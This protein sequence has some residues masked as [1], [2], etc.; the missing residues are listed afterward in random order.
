MGQKMAFWQSC[1]FAKT[2]PLFEM[3][4]KYNIG[5]NYT[6]ADIQALQLKIEL[7]E[8][9]KKKLKKKV[10]EY[11]KFEKF[12]ASDSNEREFKKFKQTR[13]QIQRVRAVNDE[14]RQMSD[15]NAI[16]QDFPLLYRITYI[17]YLNRYTNRPNPPAPKWEYPK[18][19]YIG[20]NVG[21]TIAQIKARAILLIERHWELQNQNGVEVEIPFN[22]IQNTIPGFVFAN[23]H[24]QPHLAQ[25]LRIDDQYIRDITNAP[26]FNQLIAL[27]KSWKSSLLDSLSTKS[28]NLRDGMCW[29]DYLEQK[30]VGQSGFKHLTRVTLENQLLEVTG[31]SEKYC[32]DDIIN[33]IKSN[34]YAISLYSLDPNYEVRT[35][36]IPPPNKNRNALK[37]LCYMLNNQHI[38]PIE[39]DKLFKSLG[40]GHLKSLHNYDQLNA[41]YKIN[42]KCNFQNFVKYEDNIDELIDGKCGFDGKKYKDVVYFEKNQIKWTDL[43]HRIIEKTGYAPD[44]IRPHNKS[45][46][47]P[48]SCQLYQQTE[49]YDDRFRISEVIKEEFNF[50]NFKWQNQTISQMSRLLFENVCG[51]LPKSSHTQLAINLLDNFATM[52]LTAN[53]NDKPKKYRKHYDIR[54]S[55]ASATCDI[56]SNERLP[57]HTAMDNIEPFNINVDD[58][59]LPVGLYLVEETI[60]KSG[61]RIETQW[62]PHFEVENYLIKGLI[63][64][65][66]IKLQYLARYWI[67]GDVI[68]SFV[69]FL[70]DK[71][72][73]KTANKLWHH[74]YGS[75]NCKRHKSNYA[76]ITDNEDMAMSY[77]RDFLGSATYSEINKNR[78]LVERQISERR[79]CDN[80]GL[81]SCI[82]GAGRLKL[83][84]M[85][86]SL[87]EGVILNAVRVDSVYVSFLPKYNDAMLKWEIQKVFKKGA[88]NGKMA[89]LPKCQ[90]LPYFEKLSEKPYKIECNWNPPNRKRLLR[91]ATINVDDYDLSLMETTPYNPNVDYSRSNILVQGMAGSNKT[92]MLVNNY[93]AG[94]NAGLKVRCIAYTNCAVQNLISRGI[95][96]DDAT[97]TANFLGWTGKGYTRKTSSS[98]DML[99]CDEYSMNDV[100][101]WLK[102]YAKVKSSSAIFQAFGDKNQCC[103]IEGAIKY[104]ITK[105]QFLKELLGEN[106]LLIEKFC[107]KSGDYEPRCDKYIQ[108]IV[109]RMLDHP[110]HRLPGE[111]FYPK[112]EWIWERHPTAISDTMIC[113]TNKKVD[114]LNAKLNDCIKPGCKVIIHEINDKE[115]EV[116]NGEMYIVKKL[117]GSHLELEEW[118]ANPVIR[119]KTKKRHVKVPKHY[120]K[121]A[122]ALTA[123]KYQGKT[124]YE[125]YTIFEPHLMNLQEFIV[126]LTRAKKLSQIRITNKYQLQHKPFVNVFESHNTAEILILPRL[127]EIK[128]YILKENTAKKRAYIG[129]T[130]TSLYQRLLWHQHPTSNC[131]CKDFDWNNTNI[132]LLGIYLAVSIEDNA[133]ERAYIQDFSKFSD[134]N[135]VNYRENNYPVNLTS[136]DK[137]TGKNTMKLVDLSKKFMIRDAKDSN[138]SYL[139]IQAK[140]TQRKCRYGKRRTKDEAMKLMKEARAKLLKQHYPN[141]SNEYSAV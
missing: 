107:D 84:E 39:N 124:L 87:P 72:D 32:N 52:P 70:F 59:V 110:E 89:A 103:A 67:N 94:K 50:L 114:K 113:K 34:N 4:L 80:I 8:R 2:C 35:R 69:R 18:V 130:D 117:I 60:H 86:D 13:E 27:G 17:I 38:Y 73:E 85:I 16:L 42:H 135:I 33:W 129:I 106:G 109:T 41:K 54:K 88:E 66:Q 105:T 62:L 45:F 24:S 14:V 97:T 79:Q 56:I 64:V 43:M 55:Y 100:E 98:F 123:Y 21:E 58:M 125:P 9:E 91:V 102:I 75:F 138:G 44:V 65:E 101:R 78:W 108:T 128:L 133:I 40:M 140:K 99:Q 5:I 111:L 74:F 112:Y 3:F 36:Y 77:T 68:A 71:F 115:L 118:I 19:M 127:K 26:N 57:I 119:Y 51:H 141:A 25:W 61:L 92:G 47:H 6:M 90:K 116:Y 131:K 126:S 136:N 15:P 12:V 134:Y 104:D 1:H 30:L 81:Y 53:I 23:R 83:I 137:N 20:A 22:H 76:F 31:K 121:L 29:V 37:V 49:D 11:E 95:L 122:N 96:K 139:Y 28:F 7:L 82:L 48:L 132:E 46:I 120:V 63:N 93:T 10:T